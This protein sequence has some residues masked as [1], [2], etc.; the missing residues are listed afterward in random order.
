MNIRK[1]ADTKFDFLNSF[2]T[3]QCQNSL[4]IKMDD[5]FMSLA[6]WVKDNIERNGKNLSAFETES[7]LFDMLGKVQV[8]YLHE[9]AL[10]PRREKCL[11]AKSVFCQQ[12]RHL[13]EKG[14]RL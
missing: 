10:R 1:M 11:K 4:Y 14:R 9:E 2:H 12:L 3:M 8:K 13:K 5:D 6:E 7:K